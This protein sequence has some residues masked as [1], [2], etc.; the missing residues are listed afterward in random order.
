LFS[1]HPLQTLKYKFIK[2]ILILR[3]GGYLTVRSVRKYGKKFFSLAVTFNALLTLVYAVEILAG[4]WKLNT[5]YIPDDA[6]FWAVIPAIIT[7]IFPATTIGRMKS[8]R[9]W[10]H[11]YVYGFLVSALS[12][13]LLM[14]STPVS[15]IDLFTTY[16]PDVSVNVGRF[17]I[18]GGL[19]LILDDLP[20]VSKRLSLVLSFM[21]SKVYQRRRTIHVIQCLMGFVSL[22]FL[23]AIG[24]FVI[25]KPEEANLANLFLVGT[26]LVTSLTSFGI[27]KRRIWLNTTSEEV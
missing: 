24:V 5:L 20:D 12:L 2:R 9:L 27:V 17:F 13:T 21:K 3:K 23:L 10:F 22:Y 4:V 8:G 18:I 7:N 11:H 25:Q 6:F 14:I 1:P 15:P 19:I 16:Q 26:L